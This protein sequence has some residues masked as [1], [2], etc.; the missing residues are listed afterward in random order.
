ME[1]SIT[2]IE[3]AVRFFSGGGAT[4]LVHVASNV[5]SLSSDEGGILAV[6]EIVPPAENQRVLEELGRLKAARSLVVMLGTV[7][8][9]VML[10]REALLS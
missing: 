4:E 7:V 10:T 3:A 8:L 9:S 2:V 1:T 5:A 6:R